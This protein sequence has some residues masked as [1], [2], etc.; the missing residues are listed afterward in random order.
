MYVQRNALRA[1]EILVDTVTGVNY[2]YH[3]WS[4]TGGLSVMLDKDGKPV[5]SSTS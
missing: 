5:V 2:L 3:A 1:T 4:N